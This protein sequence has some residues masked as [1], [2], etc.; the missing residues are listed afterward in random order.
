MQITDKVRTLLQKQK[1]ISNAGNI[2]YEIKQLLPDQIKK[3]TNSPHEI[4]IKELY[5]L[6]GVK[7]LAESPERP[8]NELFEYFDITEKLEALI[9]A[10]NESLLREVL[11]A[12][13]YSVSVPKGSSDCTST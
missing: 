12:L 7:P 1:M 5:S 9:K 10:Q 6:Y 13:G 3:D 4:L 8:Q 11:E 2:L